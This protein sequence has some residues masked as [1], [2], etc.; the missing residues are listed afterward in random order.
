[1]SLFSEVRLDGT[2]VVASQCLESAYGISIRDVDA[3]IL[4]PLPA[5]LQ[6]IFS[7]GLTHLVCIQMPLLC[8]I[9]LMVGVCNSADHYIFAVWFLSSFFFLFFFLA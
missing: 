1:M 3:D 8:V 9:L 5:S 6:Q 4:Y 2:A 7:A